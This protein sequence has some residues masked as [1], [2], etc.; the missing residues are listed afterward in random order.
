[1][2]G[3]ASAASKR[4]KNY[5]T[6]WHRRLGYVSERGLQELGKQGLL[7]KSKLDRLEFCEHCVFGKSTRVKF[8]TG[9]CRTNDTLDYMHLDL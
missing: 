4:I 1:M 9:E 5:T 8:G 3:N 6:L 7:E 2:V